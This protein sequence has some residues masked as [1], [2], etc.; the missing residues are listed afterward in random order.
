MDEFYEALPDSWLAR[1]SRKQVATLR[2]WTQLGRNVD[3]LVVKGVL[4][5]IEPALAEV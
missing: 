2:E 1:Q 5:K 3:A 4:R